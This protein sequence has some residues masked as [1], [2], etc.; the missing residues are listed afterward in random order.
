MA[1]TSALTRELSLK[2]VASLRHGARR[3]SQIETTVGARNPVDLSRVLKK[4]CRD[5]LIIRRVIYLGPP[6]RVEYELTDIGT[7]L[8]DPAIAMVDWIGKYRDKIATTRRESNAAK[9]AKR[10]Q[11]LADNAAP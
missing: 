8:V 9:A 11:A 4:L 2:I 6:A 5:G 1:N 7:G 10:A 3:F